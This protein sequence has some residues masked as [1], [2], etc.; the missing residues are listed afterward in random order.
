M[1]ASRPHGSPSPDADPSGE[2]ARLPGFVDELGD[3]S[4]SFDSATET[5]V[6]TLRLRR[7]FSDAPG[8][9]AALRERVARVGQLKHPAFATVQSVVRTDAGLQM[10]S[11]YASGRRLSEL[12]PIDN[13]FALALDVIRRITPA[14]AALHA[15]GAGTG[16]GALSL[17]RLVMTRDKRLIVV[18]HVLAPALE[19]LHWSRLRFNELDLVVADAVPVRLDERT[20]LRQLGWIVLSLLVARS[21]PAGVYPALARA[22]MDE[23]RDLHAPLKSTKLDQWL[24][25]ALQIVPHSF[26]FAREAQYAF[27]ELAGHE[28]LQAAESA[29]ALLAFRSEA[30][31]SLDAPEALVAPVAAPAPLAPIASVAPIAP[32]PV[33]D[34][35]LRSTP[36]VD[37]WGT[38]LLEPQLL[39]PPVAPIDRSPKL[40]AVQATPPPA[41]AVRAPRFTIA[42]GKAVWLAGALGAVA[43]FEALAIVALFLRPAVVVK[44]PQTAVLGPPTLPP[45]V[46]Q[47]AP[48]SPAQTPARPPVSP[49]PG[50]APVAAP[51]ASASATPRLGGFTVSSPIEL[52]VYKNGALVGSTAGP[53]AIS[54]GRYT[55]EFV[56]QALG[57]HATQT[58]AVTGGQV[59]PV[60]VAIPNGRVSI[61]AVPWA[62]V[63]IDGVAAGQ[64]PLGNL[65]LPIGSHQLIFR[66]PD[67]GERKQTVLVRAD[68]PTRVTET[69]R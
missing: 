12:A 63:T 33:P 54:E 58:V 43:V 42:S 24:E 65:S 26:A 13:G 4:L 62:E 27:D 40:H 10:V 41:A 64:T 48:L 68:G 23:A 11:A 19:S 21:L 44:P 49:S 22:L 47:L 9:E 8:F 56:N 51:P 38:P 20:D 7:E 55:L 53:V 67:L 60:R 16:H 6:E 45:V 30:S 46:I 32:A 31:E 1:F 18:E 14:L 69:F 39:R 57:F 5:L 35:E 66:H 36:V 3:R 17:N 61:N 15:A 28:A 59:T 29:G 2:R 37:P 52:Q 50:P 25:R 34:L